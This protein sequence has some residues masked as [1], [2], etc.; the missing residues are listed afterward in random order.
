MRRSL[1]ASLVTL[2]V[3]VSSLQ[4]QT[5]REQLQGLFTFGTCGQPLC[6]DV[7][8][9]HGAHFNPA[10]TQG[11]FT[12]IGFVTEAIA[13]ATSN[14]PISATSSGATYSIVNGLPVRTS[15]SAGPIFT[16][17]SQTLGRGRVFMGTN[18]SGIHFSSLNG[19]P[20][21]NLS[22]NFQHEDVPPTGLG[23]PSFENDVIQMGL[24]L[25]VRLLV[26]SL[27][28]TWGVTDFLDIGVAVPFERVSITGSSVAQIQPFGP[29]TPHYFAGTAANPVLRA[30]SG[31]DGSA[32]GIGDVVGRLK[33]NLGQSSR[34]GGA[35]LVEVRFP[36][37]DE[38]NLLGSGATSA[39]GMGVFSAQ[40]GSLAVHANAG[41]AVRTGELQNDGI[42]AA[43]SFDNLVA[44][45]ATVAFSLLS[46]WQVGT[47]KLVL[48]G[49]IHWTMP[50][51][52]T[53]PSTS[54][55][56]RNG[57]RL[58]ASVGAK[59]NVRQG[60]VLVLNGIVPMRDSGMQPNAAWTVGLEF[61]F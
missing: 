35:L 3:A 25:D 53:M 36:T 47:S 48:P 23:D 61:N 30:T 20:A 40:F 16:E 17:R 15:I 60:T 27:F 44:P 51:D 21:D 9:Q 10:V 18:V 54:I 42:Q 7:G 22:F 49:P 28:A 34:A 57:D 5:L 8:S 12:V 56:E 6:L 59:F 43:L 1:A 50:Y 55:P 2:L 4:A 39:R 33:V 37:G 46:E 24:G 31:M 38:Q 11:N 29:N 58:D 13:Q 45:W 52:R 32:A 26:A 19:V 41:Y 14:L